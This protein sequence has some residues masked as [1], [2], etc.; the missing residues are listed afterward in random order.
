MHAAGGG[1]FVTYLLEHCVINSNMKQ[2]V[3]LIEWSITQVP[4]WRHQ[5]KSTADEMSPFIYPSKCK[6]NTR[7]GKNVSRKMKTFKFQIVQCVQIW[8][9][10]W[11]GC[12]WL[13]L[14]RMKSK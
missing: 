9:V 13:A 7:W 4:Q 5:E 12:K 6:F 2:H 14:Q 8:N 1:A 10:Q 11:C 3:N